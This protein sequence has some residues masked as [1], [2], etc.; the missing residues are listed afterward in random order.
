MSIR[1]LVAC[2][3]QLDLRSLHELSATIPTQEIL[4]T[5]VDFAIFD[6]VLRTTACPRDHRC[7]DQEEI[8]INHHS[9]GLPYVLIQMVLIAD[10]SKVP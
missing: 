7:S 6:C 8:N 3:R 1:S 5:V 9:F 10:T 4:F 2:D